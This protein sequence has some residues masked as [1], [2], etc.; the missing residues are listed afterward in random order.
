M[1]PKRIGSKTNVSSMSDYDDRNVIIDD[2]IEKFNFEKVHVV[3]VA[4][5]WVWQTTEGDGLAVPSVARLKA[6]ARHLLREAIN[7]KHVATG[8]FVARYF[9]KVDDEPEQFTLQF[10]LE[11]V[12]SDCYD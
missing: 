5:D 9:P 12:D 8:G 11:S 10:I 2:V 3:M 1:K 4:L 6:R 7:H